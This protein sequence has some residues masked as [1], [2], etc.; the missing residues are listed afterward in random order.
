ME[1]SNRKELHRIAQAEYTE[2]RE[3]I[4]S[5]LAVLS[6]PKLLVLPDRFMGKL[7]GAAAIYFWLCV[8]PTLLKAPQEVRQAVIAHEWGH[9]ASGHCNATIGALVMALLYVLNTLA[10]PPGTFWPAVNLVLL[11]MIGAVLYWALNGLREF[12]ADNVAADAV[13]AKNMAYGLRWIVEKMRAG[14]QTELVQE[15]L[16]RLD[17]RAEREKAGASTF[18]PLKAWPIDF[19]GFTTSGQIEARINDIEPRV[20]R[21][22]EDL[23]WAT[24]EIEKLRELQWELEAGSSEE[25]PEG[26]RA[27][28]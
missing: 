15:R 3:K 7:G 26:R 1:P 18:K 21:G 20:R 24:W 10:T 11:G 25:R 9:I 12:E 6:S 16:R 8:S 13:G 22:H 2:I 4:P 5:N 28:G 27:E 23:C 14:E 19:A 17:E